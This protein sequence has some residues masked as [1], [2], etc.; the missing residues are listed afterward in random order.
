MK[1]PALLALAVMVPGVAHGQSPGPGPEDPSTTTGHWTSPPRREEMAS[2]EGRLERAVS[3]VSMPHAGILLGRSGSSR[4]YRLPGYG[5]VFVLT[6][7][8]LPGDE[9]VFVM[10]R[11]HGHPGGAVRVERQVARV[12]PGWEPERVEELE[13]QVLVLQ[14]TA[15]AHRRA[16]EEDRDRLVHDIR[17]RLEVEGT[18]GD[19]E[20]EVVEET[21]DVTAPQ[22]HD[23]PPWRFWFEAETGMDE[24]SPDTIVGDVKTA[25]LDVLDSKGEAVPGLAPDEF[26]TVAIDFVPGGFFVSHERPSRTLILRVRQ[27]DLDARAAG[28]LGSEEL[29]SRVEVI[30]Y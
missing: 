2:L 9:N 28:A 11:R 8:A 15:E 6:P 25:L 13:R 30:E 4:G 14:H 20:A 19:A 21:H 24:R 26:V 29:R 23:A 17:V 3:Q 27:K 16:A 22:E 5:I 12:P 7:R 10:R 1:I 18:G